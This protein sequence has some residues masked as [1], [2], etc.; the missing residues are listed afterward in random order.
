MSLQRK[1]FLLSYL[2][3]LSVGPAGART[4]DLRHGTLS[5]EPTGRRLDSS[6]EKSGLLNDLNG[7]PTQNTQNV[8][9]DDVICAVYKYITILSRCH[10]TCTLGVLGFQLSD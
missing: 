10:F 1:H 4:H 8:T 3:T 2:K 9:P 5:T 7:F 6:F